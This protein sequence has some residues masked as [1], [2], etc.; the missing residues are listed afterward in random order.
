MTAPNMGSLLIGSDQSDKMKEWY[1]AAFDPEM[2]D[3]GAMV[4]GNVQIFVE[5]HTLVEGPNENGHRILINFDVGDA[6]AIEAHLKTLDVNWVRPVEQEDFGLIGTIADPDGNMVQII[7][8]G[9]TPTE[10]HG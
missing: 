9:A 6:R 8:W 4:F 2:N 5:P 1:R 3:M 7:Q 10:G